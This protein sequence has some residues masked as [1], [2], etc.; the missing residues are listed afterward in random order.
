MSAET[1]LPSAFGDLNLGEDTASP[2]GTESTTDEKNAAILN[3]I[4]SS[5]GHMHY[6]M[7]VSRVLRTHKG[8]P[9]LTAEAKA[10]NRACLQCK[11]ICMGNVKANT[12]ETPTRP[13]SHISV[14]L[15]MRNIP[16]PGGNTSAL[17]ITD[18]FSSFVWASP[19]AS[20]ATNAITAPLISFMNHFG[21]P[22]LI[23]HD[24]STQWASDP[25]LSLTQ[26]WR[27]TVVGA[28]RP[29]R[30]GFA[31]PEPVRTA[32]TTLAVAIS[33]AQRE[34]SSVAWDIILPYATL[35]VNSR[36]QAYGVS[37][38][39][40]VFGREPRDAVTE[41]ATITSELGQ[42]QWLSHLATQLF[43]SAY[44]TGSHSGGVSA[45]MGL[46]AG[47]PAA[48]AAPAAAAALASAGAGASAASGGGINANGERFASDKAAA[49]SARDKALHSERVAA[50][51]VARAAK[52]EAAKAAKASAWE[53]GADDEGRDLE[54][55][56]ERSPAYDITGRG[57]N[58][59]KKVLPNLSRNEA[60][61]LL[62]RIYDQRPRAAGDGEMEY[63]CQ[64][65]LES[66]EP[67]GPEVWVPESKLDAGDV[68]RFLTFKAYVSKLKARKGKRSGAGATGTDAS[69][70]GDFGGNDE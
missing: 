3:G 45:G 33:S 19:V 62:D 15:K 18:L 21:V 66:G 58:K 41:R 26:V 53:E 51:K 13:F 23:V 22:T 60:G 39:E 9:T 8:W 64:F 65:R 56:G 12:S 47:T 31:I 7:L 61:D 14:A 37:A 17:V 27:I 28:A 68:R 55:Y 57:G 50:A 4:H 5:E 54:G 69:A 40:L 11:D 10:L 49:Q 63:R 25:F 32:G 30:G 6:S 43:G 1:W 70:G 36:R 16:T 2:N 34:F 29:G 46:G 35:F 24:N 44:Q 67:R 48:D 42:R 20:E 52:M 59:T 38:F